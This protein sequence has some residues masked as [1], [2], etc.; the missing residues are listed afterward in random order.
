MRA[1]L[2]RGYLTIGQLPCALTDVLKEAS[3]TPRDDLVAQIRKVPGAT[4]CV[5][6]EMAMYR[7][8]DESELGQI[9][10]CIWEWVQNNDWG[11][12]IPK[13]LKKLLRSIGDKDYAVPSDALLEK[14]NFYTGEK[15]LP[16][17]LFNLF[18]Q[19]RYCKPP[20]P[21]H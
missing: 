6:D 15:Y 19:I 1:E 20:C 12:Q 18:T 5:L 7:E 21:K 4:V 13:G 10:G 2:W 11:A 14:F 8:D 3:C 9:R 16:T 17:C